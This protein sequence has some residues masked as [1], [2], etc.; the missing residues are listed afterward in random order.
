MPDMI[1]DGAGQGYRAKV[2]SS[3]RLQVD[4]VSD[5]VQHDISWRLGQ[6]YQVIG[7]VTLT[8]GIVV[9]L[10]ITNVSSTHG[11][12]VTYI[13]HQ[14]LDQAG[15]T[16]FPNASNYYRIALGR[17]YVSG[18]STVTPINL[19]QGSGNIAEVTAYDSGPTL[20]G[21]ALEIDRYY[22]K[23]EGDMNLFNKEGS[24]VVAPNRTL[25]L[26]YVGDH[27]S[28]TLYTRLSFLMKEIT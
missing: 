21:T 27:S 25:E 10:H 13:R 6:A 20:D 9:V 3:N 11:V 28:G 4:S 2:S 14:I 18:G 23:A 24:V 8:S 7:T 19:N 17:K 15:G 5:S 26:A 16:G 12:V 22:T 1:L